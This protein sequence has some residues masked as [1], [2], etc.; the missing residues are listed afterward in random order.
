VI[1]AWKT[2]LERGFP[3]IKREILR[4]PSVAPDGWTAPAV[5]ESLLGID[6]EEWV[7]DRSA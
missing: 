5:I 3:F 1:A 7:D 6:V 2:L 4:D